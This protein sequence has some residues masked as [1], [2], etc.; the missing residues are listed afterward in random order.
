MGDAR[1]MRPLLR[2]L[3][4]RGRPAAGASRTPVEMRPRTDQGGSGGG[5]P[6]KRTARTMVLAPRN[7]A[8]S[9]SGETRLSAGR[10]R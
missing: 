7:Y 4:S 10:L 2:R 9:A 1:P 5:P 8:G 3:R 6:T